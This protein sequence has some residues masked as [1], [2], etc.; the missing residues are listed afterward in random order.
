MDIRGSCVLVAGATGVLREAPTAA[1]LRA[2][3]GGAAVMARRAR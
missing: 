3:P 1:L 2:G